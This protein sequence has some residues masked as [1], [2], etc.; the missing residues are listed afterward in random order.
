MFWHIKKKLIK[1]EAEIVNNEDEIMKFGTN[2]GYQTED[3]KS[4]MASEDD[5][6]EHGR[7]SLTSEVNNT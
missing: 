1:V 7:S 3:K 2:M 5:T 4:S 6:P